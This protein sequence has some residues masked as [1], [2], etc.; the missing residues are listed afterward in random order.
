MELPL[1]Q[2][3]D[4]QWGASRSTLGWLAG[5]LVVNGSFL[6]RLLTVGTSRYTGFGGGMMSLPWSMSPIGWHMT[7]SPY[8]YGLHPYGKSGKK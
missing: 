8:Q 1:A 5:L 3:S 6:L 7:A 2:W 4:M